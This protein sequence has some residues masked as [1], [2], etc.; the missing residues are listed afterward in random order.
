MKYDIEVKPG[1]SI[2]EHE[3]EITTSRSSGPGG[4]HVNT[5]NTRITIRWN[6]HNTN[7]LTPPQ[8]ERAQ[9]KLQS[10]LTNEGDI[11]ISH[12]SGRSQL[13][14]KELALKQLANELR[15]ALHVPKKRMATK[16]S[17][18]VK[19]A[20]LQTKARRSGVK[21]MRNKRNFDE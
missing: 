21:K 11:I 18:G 7:A 13:Q 20:R 10:R 2:P 12:S 14:N 8:K 19:E 4:Q 6:L 17:K 15:N 16:I 5:S 3:I 9:Q 1:I